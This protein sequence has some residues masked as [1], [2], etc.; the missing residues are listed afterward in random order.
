MYK[1]T[2]KSSQLLK[3]FWLPLNSRV[4][5]FSSKICKDWTLKKKGRDALPKYFTHSLA[6]S[7][8]CIISSGWSRIWYDTIALTIDGGYKLTRIPKLPGFLICDLNRNRKEGKET[9]R[10]VGWVGINTWGKITDLTSNFLKLT[11]LSSRSYTSIMITQ[12]LLI[13]KV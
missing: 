2:R 6:V 12:V 10:V 9:D 5:I 11:I 4:K 13:T 7:I 3:R 1:N 8:S